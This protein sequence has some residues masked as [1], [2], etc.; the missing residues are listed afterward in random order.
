MSFIDKVGNVFKTVGGFLKNNSIGANL[1]KSALLGLALRKVS[2]SIEADEESKKTRG[3]KI[4][5]RPDPSNSIPLIYGESY[6]KGVIT[7]AYLS[8]DNT[9][10]WVCLT[11]CEKT[12]NKIDGTPSTFTFE[13]AYWNGFR[14]NFAANGYTVASYTD[15][16]G[17]T[18]NKIAGLIEVY[19]FNGSST[20]PTNFGSGGN[21]QPAYSLMPNWSTNYE[22][23]DLIFCIVKITYSSK[24]RVTSIGEFQFKVTNSM[25]D[26][27]DVIYDYMTNTRYGAGIPAAEIDI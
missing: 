15:D 6:A 17:T 23:N 22:M 25:S 1:A 7:D 10:M 5:L 18:S 4:Q 9:S 26:P 14:L 24:N 21:T 3:T 20:D 8:P 13:E 19:P 16:S 27:G 12:G 11:I 2:K